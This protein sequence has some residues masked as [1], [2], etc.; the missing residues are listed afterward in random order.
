[1]D[2]AQSEIRELRLSGDQPP[3]VASLASVMPAAPALMDKLVSEFAPTAD[4]LSTQQAY[5]VGLN[6]WMTDRL[7]GP[8]MEGNVVAE[9]VGE[10]AW[11]IYA[12]SCWGGMELREHW[13]M[14]PALKN[15]GMTPPKP[16]ACWSPDAT[17]RR[18]SYV[19]TPSNGVPSEP[20]RLQPSEGAGHSTT[21]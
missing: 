20:G 3:L 1:M 15:M 19:L 10:Q 18:H 2:Q 7:S 21:M 11:A 17:L 16:P 14:P 4:T 9:E 5:W 6:G 13:G 8:I 12:T